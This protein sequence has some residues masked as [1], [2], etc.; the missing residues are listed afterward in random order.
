MSQP[1]TVNMGK[2]VSLVP[3][4]SGHNYTGM[5]TRSIVFSTVLVVFLAAT[6]MTIASIIVPN[7]LGYDS[8][9]VR[10]PTHHGARCDPARTSYWTDC[11]LRRLTHIYRVMGNMLPTSTSNSACTSS[12]ATSPRSNTPLPLY[13]LPSPTPP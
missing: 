8:V 1:P 13:S 12:V 5:L 4:G 6:G 3:S 9:V 11:R 2:G 7:W 10:P